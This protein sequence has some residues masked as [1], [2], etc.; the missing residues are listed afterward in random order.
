MAG[1]SRTSPA[2]TA[3]HLAQ[4][5]RNMLSCIDSMKSIICKQWSFRGAAKAA[6]PLLRRVVMDS[7]LAA[8]RR[9]GM[10]AD[11][12]RISGTPH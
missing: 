8:S 12:I 7:G 5:E 10:T 11:K 3:L 4:H 6:N 9:P 2:M 1:T